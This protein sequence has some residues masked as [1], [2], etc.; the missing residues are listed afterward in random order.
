MR[1][2]QHQIHQVNLF[3]KI[4]TKTAIKIL[5]E[6][7]ILSPSLASMRKEQKGAFKKNQTPNLNEMYAF[8]QENINVLCSR[9]QP[10]M[11]LL[12]QKCK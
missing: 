7:M 5:N 6:T 3:A 11:P 1:Y 8:F 9:Q 4:I 12:C 10:Q 2:Y